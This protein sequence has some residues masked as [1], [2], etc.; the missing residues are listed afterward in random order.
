MS[1]VMSF[2]DQGKKSFSI[3]MKITFF[4]A[5][6]LWIGSASAKKIQEFSGRVISCHDGDTCR[7]LVNEKVMKVRLAGIDAP[8]IKQVEGLAAR[9]HLEKLVLK[10][11]VR[12]LCDGVSFDRITCTI[13][14]GF[15]NVNEELVKNGFAL[16]SSRY[17]RGV[18]QALMLQAQAKKLGI[19]KTLKV[20]PY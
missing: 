4:L 6:N 18:Y 19:W 14:L 20:S 12:L 13:F 8:E 7:I 3:V 15:T 5:V 9:K 10:R 1:G 16:D 2:M 11:P 17:S